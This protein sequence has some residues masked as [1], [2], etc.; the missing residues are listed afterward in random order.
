MPQ[1]ITPAEAAAQLKSLWKSHH[2]LKSD[3]RNMKTM[4]EQQGIMLT[5]M[6]G[7]VRRIADV[8]AGPPPNR[9]V[10]NAMRIKALEESVEDLEEKQQCAGCKNDPRVAS[11]E[12]AK[13]DFEPRL[14][15]LETK[16][17]MAVGAL[18]ALQIGLTA[19]RVFWK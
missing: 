6:N 9:C 12:E 2:E 19:F 4:Q 14:R 15:A 3:V 5:E 8:I 11:L 16:M 7:N 1:S 10:E 17:W 13:K 18:A